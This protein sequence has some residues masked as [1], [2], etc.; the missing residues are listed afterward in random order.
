MQ[1][2]QGMRQPQVAMSQSQ[3]DLSTLNLPFEMMNDQQQLQQ[4]PAMSL[5]QPDISASKVPLQMNEQ[6]YK[7]PLFLY[8]Q[9]Q[10]IPGPRVTFLVLILAYIRLLKPDSVI[11][12]IHHQA[13]KLA[14]ILFL[15]GHREITVWTC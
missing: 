8:Q 4:H 15:A 12:Q 2:G 13:T 5:H 11:F 9:Q 1:Q 14:Q 7:L 6:N 3:P 10:P